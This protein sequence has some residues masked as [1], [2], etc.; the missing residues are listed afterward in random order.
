MLVTIDNEHD[1]LRIKV[2]DREGVVLYS[3]PSTNRLENGY[4][5]R[6]EERQLHRAL[7]AFCSHPV[8]GA[9]LP[10]SGFVL[11][12]PTIDVGEM[13]YPNDTTGKEADFLCIRDERIDVVELKTKYEKK[14]VRQLIN[15]LSRVSAAQG[16]NKDR[17]VA[18]R[19][20]AEKAGWTDLH[21]YS[22]QTYL[23]A[24]KGELG[25]TGGSLTGWLVVCDSQ[26]PGEDY[27]NAW[28]RSDGANP[29]WLTEK[30]P[31]RTIARKAEESIPDAGF[32]LL[33]ASYLRSVHEDEG[34]VIDL[35]FLWDPRVVWPL[36]KRAKP[37]LG[38]PRLSMSLEVTGPG[39]VEPS[40]EPPPG[41]VGVAVTWADRDRV[42]RSATW[43]SKGGR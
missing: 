1:R 30:K 34:M 28:L 37:Q 2:D 12:T 36:A 8:A 11:S 20:V 29:I 17:V 31:A 16:W 26:R 15:E 38:W 41:L 10:F 7:K 3:E 18:Q 5:P 27:L 25:L 39:A 40:D 19:G 23:E 33:V 35:V 22:P 21:L 9:S 42:F 32:Q 4:P 14:N 6:Y 13:P 43:E 24:T